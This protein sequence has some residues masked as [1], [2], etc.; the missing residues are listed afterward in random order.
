MVVLPVK[1]NCLLLWDVIVFCCHCL[2]YLIFEN[3]HFYSVF[4]VSSIRKCLAELPRYFAGFRRCFGEFRQYFAGFRQ[5][6]G[7]YCRYL[8]GIRQ[9]SAGI[10]RCLA[11][12]RQCLARFREFVNT[13]HRNNLFSMSFN[14]YHLLN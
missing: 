1:E 13:F 6:L 9:C 8:A 5:C 11:G 7:E 2:L 4:D 12:S 14:R 10:P 3:I